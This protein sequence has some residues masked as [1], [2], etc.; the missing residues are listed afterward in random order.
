V[1]SWLLTRNIPRCT[2][3]EI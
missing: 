3:N 2:V 1:S